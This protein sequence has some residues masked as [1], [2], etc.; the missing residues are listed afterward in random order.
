MERRNEP[1]PSLS[2]TP[3]VSILIATYNGETYLHKQLDSIINQ[4]YRNLEIIIQDDG[5]TDNTLKILHD[6]ASS[7]P[8]IR[9]SQNQS[10]LGIIQNFY[11]LISKGSGKYIAISDQDDI[12]EL[13]KIE[14]LLKSISGASLIYTDSAL[15][16]DDDSPW[17]LT[18]LE[19][20]G[21]APKSG[22][23][24]MDLL[25]ENTISGHACLFRSDLKQIILK[26]RHLKFHDNFMYDQLIGTI[27]SFNDGVIYY[28]KPL[29]HHR[30]HA[31]NNHNTFSLNDSNESKKR[32]ADS[33]LPFFQRKLERARIKNQRAYDKLILLE[34]MFN[35][36]SKDT[37][38]LEPSPT[39]K[40]KTCFFNRPL[41]RALVN[42][43]MKKETAKKLSYGKL[44]Y[45]YLKV[46]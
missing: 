37:S 39:L 25:T 31:S 17:G 11:D 41:F 42:L 45:S 22:K 44:Y 2:M 38:A 21:H 36:Y 46:F 35:N 27:A 10:N 13:D 18:L 40:F 8:R 28:D 29:T 4:T 20:L 24:L 34:S 9:V 6:Y 12:W 26:N 16:K 7:D 14:V 1:T 23:F 3:K 5:S 33:K 30:I 32:R 19:K 15:I 43:G